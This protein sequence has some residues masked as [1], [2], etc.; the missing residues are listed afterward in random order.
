MFASCFT[1]RHDASMFA[2][3]T[4]EKRTSVPRLV[5]HAW[6]DWTWLRPHAC[7]VD[8]WRAESYP[9][10]GRLAR[11]KALE[12]A[13]A[14]SLD[15]STRNRSKHQQS[16]QCAVL[17]L[18]PRWN[19]REEEEKRNSSN[20]E[21]ARWNLVALPSIPPCCLSPRRRGHY[22]TF[23]KNGASEHAVRASEHA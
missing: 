3:F 12:S 10:F 13:L 6:P 1:L 17:T 18:E 5:I 16:W 11:L 9:L 7:F 23:V 14:P 2:S 15:A 19:Q 22:G 21:V 20:T 8:F 4:P